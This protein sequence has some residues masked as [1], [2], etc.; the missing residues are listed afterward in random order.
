M[1]RTLGTAGCLVAALAACRPA[2]PSGLTLLFL[3][4]SPT[5]QLAGLSW[6]P[7]PDK[8]RIVA[9]DSHLVP[10]RTLSVT[11]LAAPMAVAP[12]AGDLLVTEQMGSAV[13]LDT[14]GHEVREWESINPASLYAS[15]GRTIVAARSPYYV[16][17]FH[18]E[19]VT[20]PLFRM[21]DT[22]GHQVA[23]LATIREGAFLAQ[24]VNAGALAMDSS[25]AIYFA[26]LV[27]DEIQKYSPGGALLW[28]TKRGIY[29]VET[30]P[31]GQVRGR[32]LVVDKAIVNVALAIGPAGRLYSLGSNDS[33]ATRLRV[34][35]LDQASGR[36]L[37]THN[38][39]STQTAVAVDGGGGLVFFDAEQL[40]SQVAVSSG[41][42]T[43]TPAFALPDLHGDTVSLSRFAGKVTLVNFWAS[44]CDPCREEFPH[45]AELY[46]RFSRRDFEIAAISDDV[47]GDKMRVFAAQYRPPFPILVG[48]GRMKGIYHYRG[49]PYSVLLDRRGRI[50]E[51]IFGFGGTREFQELAAAIAKEIVAP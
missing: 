32:D 17:E 47:D 48:G 46:G 5:A 43:F 23:G 3:R 35:V 24:V 15:N 39:D 18:P 29:P 41:R 28:T 26:P 1:R 38:L 37:E 9:F 40:L 20:E 34:D 4:R 11:A 10:V 44:W 2:A 21:L 33:G 49:L 30:E 12:L 13:L 6:A 25:G 16:P 22:L 45:M 19:P 36:I 14:A 51:R 7:D 42:E 50:I 8:S 31:R 27:R